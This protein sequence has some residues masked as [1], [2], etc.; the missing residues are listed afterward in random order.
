LQ[1]ASDYISLGE[2]Q[3]QAGKYQ[4]AIRDW[5]HAT[6]DNP[7]NGGLVLLMSQALFA[8]GQYDEAAG[9][10]QMS[11]QMLPDTEWGTVVKEYK[12]LYPNIQNYTDQ[13]KA[14]ERA[15]D[16]KLDDPAIR[17]L[18]GYHFGYLGYPKEAVRELDKGLELQPKDLGAQKLR[19]IFAVKAGL[20]AR[21]HTA[22]EAPAGGNQPAGNPAQG[23][24]APQAAPPVGTPS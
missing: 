2:Q 5:R 24:Q 13:L 14:L 4:E 22:E 12:Q 15:R 10:V 3:F 20:P 17:F 8:L 19:D 7:N 18:L 6:V 23:T 9:A 1:A 16:A 21:P 11:M